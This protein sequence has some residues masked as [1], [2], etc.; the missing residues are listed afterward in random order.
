ML[1]THYGGQ[2]FAPT[3]KGIRYSMNTHP[4]CDS[5]L[6][7]RDQR[8]TATFRYRNRAEITV[9]KCEEK[10]YTVWFSRRRKTYLV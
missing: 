1:L 4:I 3:L 8:S 7:I 10:P 9:L 5:P 6:L 2:L